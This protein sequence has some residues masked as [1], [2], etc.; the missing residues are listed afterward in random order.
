MQINIWRPL[1][2]VV[3]SSPLAFADTRTIKMNDLI[4][5]DQNF[6]DRKGEIY[7]LAYNP[8][9]SWYWLPEMKN[10]EVL[11]L[12]GWDTAKKKNKIEFSTLGRHSTVYIFILRE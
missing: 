7:H 5:T 10:T 1:S 3:L 4:A 8:E 9:Q 12:K 6:P 2:E 11:L